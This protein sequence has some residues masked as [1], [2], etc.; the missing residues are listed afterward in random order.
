MK[1][2]VGQFGQSYG[3]KGWLKIHSLTDPPENILQ[4]VPWQTQQQNQWRR[5]TVTDTKQQGNQIL[6]KLA[7]CD[8]PETAKT[9]TNSPI[10]IEQEQLPKLAAEEYYWND[11]VGLTVINQEG[12]NFGTVDSLFATGSNDVL[13]VKGDRQRL[14]P[15]TQDVI[16]S[17]DLAGKIMRVNWEADF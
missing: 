17:V 11:L 14:L 9:Y 4:Y 13:V 12:V 8:S 16:I 3:I 10:A 2:I 5:V 6:V 1:I 15:Y 7:E